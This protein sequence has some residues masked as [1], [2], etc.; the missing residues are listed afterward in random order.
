MNIS[1]TR[2]IDTNL[3]ADYE[4]KQYN[5]FSADIAELIDL[6]YA[7]HTIN[8]LFNKLETYYR[9]HKSAANTLLFKKIVKKYFEEKPLTESDAKE[10]YDKLHT[11]YIDAHLMLEAKD[12][13][14][15]DPFRWWLMTSLYDALGERNKIP[16]QSNGTSRW[17]STYTSIQTEKLPVFIAHG[18][19]WPTTHGDLNS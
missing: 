11:E 16:H 3:T 1:S 14:K 18:H 2:T 9:T 12:E 13:N 15:F 4:I 5:D 17:H 10:F 6:R 7:P 19:G 8:I